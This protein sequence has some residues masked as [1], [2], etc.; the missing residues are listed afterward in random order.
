LVGRNGGQFGSYGTL[1][2]A[3]ATNVPGGRLGATGW[4]DGSGNLWFFGGQGFDSIGAQGNL[5][6]VWEF[7]P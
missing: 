1:G 3:A 2:T 5:N 4:V 6:D 7:Q